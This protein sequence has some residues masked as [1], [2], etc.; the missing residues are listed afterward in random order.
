MPTK[1]IVSSVPATD[2]LSILVGRNTARS[3]VLVF[4]QSNSSL[5]LALTDE[6]VSL[7]KF[8]INLLPDDYYE[9]PFGYIGSIK[10]L[11]LGSAISGKA[12][13]TELVHQ[14]NFT[15]ESNWVSLSSNIYTNDEGD[16]YFL[17]PIE[18]P[19]FRLGVFVNPVPIN[20]KTGG[21]I[22]LIVGNNIGNDTIFQSSRLKL[23]AFNLIK[24]DRDFI[25]YFLKLEI[26]YWIKSLDLR[27]QKYIEQ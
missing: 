5:Y 3:G 6:E 13:I 4:N 12:L 7:S 23:N 10:G 1:G 26:P 18:V 25:P 14:H 24:A 27:I 20:W 8:T 22:H 17:D 11:W 2:S 21:W 16:V 19:I 15:N 9:V